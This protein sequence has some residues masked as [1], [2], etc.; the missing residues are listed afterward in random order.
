MWIHI[1]KTILVADIIK[2]ITGNALNKKKSKVLLQSRKV[3][4]PLFES[5]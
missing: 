4:R 5:L 2:K 1:K 3:K